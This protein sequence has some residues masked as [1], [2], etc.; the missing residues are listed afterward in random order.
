MGGESSKFLRLERDAESGR[1]SIV[2]Y[3]TNGDCAAGT[4]SFID[5]QATRQDF[6]RLA[7]ERRHECGIGMG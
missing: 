4:G 2:D 3:E 6:P 7:S 1:V 5:Q